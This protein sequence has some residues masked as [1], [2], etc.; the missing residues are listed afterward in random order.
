HRL[1]KK[2]PAAKIS[3]AVEPII[4]YLDAGVPEPI[5]SALLDGARW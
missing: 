3:A 4:Y 1:V 2:N 5:K